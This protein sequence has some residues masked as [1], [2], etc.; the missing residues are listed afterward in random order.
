MSAGPNLSIAI[1][2][3]VSLGFGSPQ[4]QSLARSLGAHYGAAVTIFEPDQSGR[5]PQPIADATVTVRRMP[6]EVSPHSTPGRIEYV[7]HTARELNRERP[8]IVVL[9]CTFSLPVLAKLD[10]RPRLVI[11]ALIEMVSPYGPHDLA[12]NRHLASKIDLLIFP[13][14]NR[15]R[16]DAQRC[17]FTTKPMAILYNVS[18]ASHALPTAPASRHRRLFYGGAISSDPGLADYFLH[19]DARDVPLDLYGEVT[20]ADRES[21]LAKLNAAA[22]PRYQGCVDAESLA[23]SRRNYAYSLVMY[24]PNCE[25]THYAAPNKL[26]EA[27][28]DGVP[29]IVAPH[30]QCQ[31]LVE[32]Y[33]CG[34]VMRD[35]SFE[36]YR[37]AI[38][39]ALRAFGTRRYRRMIENC[40]VA[41]QAELNWQA[42]FAKLKRI[43]PAA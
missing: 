4:V 42:Q 40:A 15:A 13:E 6:T 38:R 33:R 14:E 27:I 16:L 31:M 19:P 35:W 26:F 22:E 32:R 29:P 17:G 9:F 28:A 41:V 25:H 12:M 39:E 2:S 24:R 21:L 43:L 37:E 1:V 5:P 11:Y 10:Y 36:A 8:E 7:L 23:R 30:P 3:D 18:D 20:G 34:I